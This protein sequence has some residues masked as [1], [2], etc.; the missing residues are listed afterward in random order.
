MIR[1]NTGLDPSNIVG[2]TVLIPNK[3]W[4]ARLA[5]STQCTAAGFFG[6]H[7]FGS[8]S[9]KPAYVIQR[10]D[11]GLF[12]PAA[13]DYLTNIIAAEDR[14]DVRGQWCGPRRSLWPL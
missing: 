8:S 7:A 1:T 13:A 2:E 6:L 3:L 12:Y 9:P 4:D 14:R 10:T 5:G 11:N